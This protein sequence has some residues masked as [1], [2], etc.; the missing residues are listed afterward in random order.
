MYVCMSSD[1]SRNYTNSLFISFFKFVPNTIREF[2]LVMR[3]SWIFGISFW[4]ADKPQV[5]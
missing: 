5:I 1:D 4:A 2:R 3:F